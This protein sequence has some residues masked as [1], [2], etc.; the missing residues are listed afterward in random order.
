MK[1]DILVVGSTALDSV[2]TAAGRVDDAVGG[3][4][5]FFAAAASLF[6]P[7]RLVGVVGDDFPLERL[8]FLRRRGVSL[9]G[10][11]VVPGGRTFRWGGRYHADGIG[12]DTLFTELG[13]F[14]EFRPRVP[15]AARRAPLLFLANIQPTLQLQVLEQVEAPELVVVDT[16][17]LWINTAR[18]ELLEVIA[19]CGALIVNDEEARMITGESRLLHAARRL[20]ELGPGLVVV[21]KGEHGALLLGPDGPFALPALP[22]DTVVDP[23]GAGDSFAGGFVGSLAREA[24]FDDAACR[25][26]MV[27]GTVLGACAC[28]GFSLDGLARLDIG[29]VERRLAELRRLTEIPHA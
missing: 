10:L 29:Q 13:V 24:R 20:R 15:E 12:R 8:E 9:D 27:C 22:L 25:R 14:E 1:R 6:A 2:E 26:A 11:Q 19:R 4:A 5:F 23:T 17:N 18:G 3:S 7:V 16:M 21:K 28:E